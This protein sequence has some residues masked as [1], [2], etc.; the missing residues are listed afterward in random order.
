MCIAMQTWQIHITHVHVLRVLTT[1]PSLFA[2][3]ATVVRKRLKV[4]LDDD[5]ARS[6]SNYYCN[7]YGAPICDLYHQTEVRVHRIKLCVSGC[8]GPS[9]LAAHASCELS[10]APALSWVC[11]RWEQIPFACKA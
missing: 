5:N 11:G 3:A 2:I 1:R 9:A 7:G 4:D 10:L 6:N 8:L